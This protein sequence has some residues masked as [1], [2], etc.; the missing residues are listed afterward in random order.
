MSEL[1][2]EKSKDKDKGIY[3]RKLLDNYWLSVVC[4]FSGIYEL[5]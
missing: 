1:L 4:P 5:L 3:E 2:L